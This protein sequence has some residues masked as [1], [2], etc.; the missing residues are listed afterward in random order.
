MWKQIDGFEHYDVS[1][2]GEVRT[3]RKRPVLW[4]N[5]DLTDRHKEPKLMKLVPNPLGYTAVAL[6][7]KR[8]TKPKR[9]T[10]HRLVA[11]TFLPNP[12]NHSDVAHLNGN[13]SDNLVSNLA[14]MTH[15]DNQLMMQEHGTQYVSSKLTADQVKYIREKVANGPR[16]TARR[17]AEKFGVQ[18]PQISRIVNGTRW[19]K[20]W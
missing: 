16:G 6:R 12:N 4:R 19:K 20:Y 18:P 7:G 14:W 10:V 11:L 3:W 5:P 9:M 8:G 2:S 15:Q 13:P 17:M 1:D